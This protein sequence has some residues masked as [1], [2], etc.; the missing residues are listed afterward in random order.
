M[1]HLKES[2]KTLGLT[3]EEIVVY[4]CALQEGS[5]TALELARLT[6][7]PRTTVYLLIDAL[8][9]KGL[10]SLP[11]T[12]IKKRYVP[13]SPDA[14]LK[15]ATK[16]QHALSQTLK[17]LE[18]ELPQLKALY[19]V[20]H[21]KPVLRYF[22]GEDVK[23]IY[24]EALHEGK[25]YLQCPTLHGGSILGDFRK[26]YLDGVFTSFAHSF[27]M[28]PQSKEGKAYQ[29][30]FHSSRNQ[31]RLFPE[32]Y[33]ACVDKLLFGDSVAYITYPQDRV[34]G[35]VITDKDIAHAEKIQYLTLWERVK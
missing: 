34:Q 25:I 2:L 30:E 8:T 1:H 29:H 7:I 15:V 23:K 17:T 22:T 13:A 19:E 5:A 24:A 32:S 12:A 20:H 26:T 27:E 9:E 10:L 4:L 28:V 14:L 3:D 11:D 35:I 21:H 16:K 18:D 6:D 33:T 31:I